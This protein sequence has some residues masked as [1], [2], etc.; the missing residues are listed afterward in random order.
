[1]GFGKSLKKATK[2]VTNSVSKTVKS[3][4]S[5]MKSAVN[6][7]VDVTVGIVSGEYLHKATGKAVQ[8]L[9]GEIL[10]D[11]LGL[12]KIGNEVEQIGSDITQIGKVLGGEYHDDVK[13]ITDEQNRVKAYGDSLQYKID[14]YN[15][16]LQH[17]QDRVDSL[18]AF[19]EI[20]KM[21]I[22]NRTEDFV[23]LSNTELTAMTEQ[24]NTMVR[25]L[26]AMVSNLKSEYDFV[27]G[28][29]QGSFVERLVGSVIMIVGGLASD[30]REIG[31]GRANSETWKRIS[32]TV[33]SIIAI[34]AL[35]FVPGLQGV[36][37]ALAV[38]LASISLFL[39]LDG[40][41]S[42]GAATGAIMGMLDFLFNDVL[43]LD[44]TIGSDFNK[45]D[46][47]HEDYQQ[48]VGYVKLSIM[49]ASIAA[50]WTSAPT[51]L[52][53]VTNAGMMSKGSTAGAGSN[54]LNQASAS[55]TMQSTGTASVGSNPT[56]Y[57]GGTIQVGKTLSDT[58]VFGLKFGTYSDIY[59][60]YT[61][62]SDVNDVIAMYDQHKQLKDKLEAD[63]AKVNEA[64]ASKANKSM[65]KHYKDSAY[66][67]Q[68]QQEFIDRY[69]WSMTSQSMYVDPYGTTPVANIRFEPDKDTR[70]ISFG[71][72]DVF[73][74]SKQAGS[75]AYFNNIIY[76][77]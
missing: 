44:D 6:T 46:K 15:L 76:G 26:N 12:D 59:K 8:F 77:G 47:D 20:Y 52:D 36:S 16:T 41:Y 2:S 45:F 25:N 61:T 51:Q 34:A 13:A 35:F 4:I 32:I 54:A 19:D 74:E 58:S 68:D 14:T 7:V 23:E 18:I 48:M 39:S 70:G 40:M 38:T 50:A 67:L 71:F 28:L 37:L 9:G 56:A 60:A 64:L 63:M 30:F 73:S 33:V 31:S 10:D 55:M 1:M 65:M 17:L 62:A 22:N 43:N 53:S 29:T 57:L 49:L 3:T 11:A 66:F 75:R 24:Y 42:N 27:I 69:I 21:A 5:A 72:E